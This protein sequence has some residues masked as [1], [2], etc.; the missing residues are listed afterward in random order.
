MKENQSHPVI[1]SIMKELRS[2]TPKGRIIGKYIMQHPRKAVFM[3]TRELAETCEVSEATVVRFVNQLGYGAYGEFLQ[4]LR[5]YVDSGLT[6]QDRI[7]LPGM[8]EPGTNR[9]H[10]VVFDEMNNLTQF[11]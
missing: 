6:L 9:F 3:T 2:L 4:A 10:R 8:K 1:T 5:D 7:D 11:Y